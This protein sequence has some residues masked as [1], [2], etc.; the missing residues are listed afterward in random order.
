ML[1]EVCYSVSYTEIASSLSCMSA[2]PRG[3]FWDSDPLHPYWSP[4]HFFRW[5]VSV[6]SSSKCYESAASETG[7]LAAPPDVPEPPM[8]RFSSRSWVWPSNSEDPGGGSHRRAV[9][10]LSAS[11]PADTL[12]RE[13][14]LRCL[15]QSS[16]LCSQQAPVLC[17]FLA[18][19]GPGGTGLF[20]AGR[21]QWHQVS[22]GFSE[23]AQWF[24]L[25]PQI[26][27]WKLADI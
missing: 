3:S 16:L 12:P 21:R 20:R 25:R 7:L 5:T 2:M 23:S 22:E 9:C 18:V 19:E 10:S 6:F 4:S 8:E 11:S 27:K 14:I 15:S 1:R 13:V 17:E 24:L 26:Y